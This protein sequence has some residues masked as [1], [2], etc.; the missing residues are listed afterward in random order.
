MLSLIL[1]DRLSSP[2]VAKSATEP[3]SLRGLTLGCSKKAGKIKCR[4]KVH[5]I[6]E[7][8]NSRWCTSLAVFTGSGL[9]LTP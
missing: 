2:G 4:R 6:R 9:Y 7:V 5:F 8:L 1:L 3:E